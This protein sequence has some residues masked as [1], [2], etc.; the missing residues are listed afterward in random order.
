MPDKIT[1]F[2]E[3]LDKKLRNQLKKKLIEL[4]KSPFLMKN[5]KRMHTRKQGMY[6]LRMG[7]IRIVYMVVNNIVEIVDIDYRGNIY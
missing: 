6:R 5:V 2:V 1:K 7:K 3:S 4:K